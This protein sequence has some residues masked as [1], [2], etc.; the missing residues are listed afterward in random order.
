MD[1]REKFKLDYD[2]AVRKLR[3]ARENRQAQDILRRDEKVLCL[4]C[5]SFPFN[6]YTLVKSSQK[7]IG[8]VHRDNHEKN[9]SI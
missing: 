6:G 8:L 7:C 2:S 4:I 5:H 1:C 9:E 3:D